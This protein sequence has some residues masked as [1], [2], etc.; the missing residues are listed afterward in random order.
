M[1]IDKENMPIV[2]MEFMNDVHSEDI[3]IINE[4]FELILAY[5][6]EPNKQNKQ[7][8]NQKYKEWFDHTVE[9]FKGE[10][11]MMEQKQFPP[12]PFHKGEHDNALATMD[13]VFKKWEKTGDIQI[14][15]QYFIETLPAWL[16]QHIQSMDT[17]TAMFFKTGLSPCSM[18]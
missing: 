10:E 6:K 18:K 8:L 2:A 15:K 12:Y 1:L 3:D 13:N 5:E 9:H 16:I 7:S 4:L 11:I 17:V 14:L